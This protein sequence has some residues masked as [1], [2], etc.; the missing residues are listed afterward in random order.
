MTR[1]N[2]HLMM[3]E[4]RLWLGV[5]RTA[6]PSDCTSNSHDFRHFLFAFNALHLNNNNQSDLDLKGH[7]KS[8]LL[9]R[10]NWTHLV[11]IFWYSDSAHA[12]FV[13]GDCYL[14]KAHKQF[15]VKNSCYSKP[16][17]ILQYNALQEKYEAMEKQNMLLLQE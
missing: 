10:L 8:N 2:G 9:T 1:P 4:Q 6:E 12:T 3:L 14:L 16:E 7:K 13:W 11:L 17:G 5:T 15:E